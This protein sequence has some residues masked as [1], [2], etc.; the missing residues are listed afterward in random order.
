MSSVNQPVTAFAAS[1]L[2]SPAHTAPQALNPQALNPQAL[3]PQSF[4][5]QSFNPM[6][7]RWVMKRVALGVVILVVAFGSIAWL[8]YAS[9]EQGAAAIDDAE[10]ANAQ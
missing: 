8:T 9:I 4:N 3:N 7:L 10:T 1:S 6:T 2:Q 5:P